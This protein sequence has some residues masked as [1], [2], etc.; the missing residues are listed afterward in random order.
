MKDVQNR[1]SQV[2]Q[3]AETKPKAKRSYRKPALL[4][5]KV[6]V[7][8]LTLSLI[9]LVALAL[10]NFFSKPVAE[11]QIFISGNQVI[12]EDEVIEYLHLQ[13]LGLWHQVDSY[14][15][16][17]RLNQHPWVES[18]SV[19]KTINHGLSVQINETR[20]IAYL[21]TKQGLFLLSPDCRVLS[22]IS[23]ETWKDLPIIIHSHLEE[24]KPGIYLPKR[25]LSKVFEILTLLEDTGPLPKNAISEIDISD[26]LNTVLVTIPY[27]I[28]IKLGN[29]QYETKLTN[30]QNALPVLL[31]ERG[32]IRYIDLRYQKAIVYKKKV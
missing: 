15:L 31:K 17:V 20:P 30:L 7:S 25:Q 16:S 28:R 14:H 4:I 11:N 10:P 6:S 13:E 21:K 18:A 23:S 12:S 2:P 1:L 19:H 22:I 3:K 9:A 32:N 24:V 8:L 27:G 26:P 5:I 29:S